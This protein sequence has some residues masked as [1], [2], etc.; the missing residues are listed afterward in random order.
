MK[1]IL[2]WGDSITYGH[3]DSKGGWAARFQEK[4]WDKTLVYNLGIPGDTTAEILGRFEFEARQR[5]D[6]GEK[7]I[8]VF[9][10]GLN[11][12]IFLNDRGI[13][14]TSIDQFIKNLHEIYTRAKNISSHVL[15]V[16]L[17]PVDDTKTNP[18][19]WAPNKVYKNEY[20]AKYDQALKSFC[21]EFSIPFVDV[22]SVW[23][24]KNYIGWLYDGVHPNK[25]GYD[26]LLQLISP[27]LESTV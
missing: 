9:A 6:P 25:E 22:F 11:D 1:N 21:R 17:T 20:I 26:K 27:R 16:G 5:V 18:V 15:F 10:I 14:Q 2:I 13:S 4:V 19:P 8:L 12:S 3:G 7:T 24:E 23:R